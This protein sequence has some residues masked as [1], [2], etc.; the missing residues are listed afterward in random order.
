MVVFD[1]DIE[2]T[3]AD[4]KWNEAIVR[5]R[6]ILNIG[7]GGRDDY[8]SLIQLIRA[9]IRAVA[10]RRTER[11]LGMGFPSSSTLEQLGAHLARES[12]E[13]LLTPALRGERALISILLE[14]LTT[15]RLSFGDFVADH[16]GSSNDVSSMTGHLGWKLYKA[17][18]PADRAFF[19]RT[20][21][22]EIEFA[23]LPPHEQLFQY[24]DFTNRFQ[25]QAIEARQNKERNYTTLLMPGVDKFAETFIRDKALLRC[26]VTA[27]AAERYRLATSEWPKTL[28]DL[29]PV[30]MSAVLLD[31]YDGNPLKYVVR[32]DGFTIYSTGAD[33]QD[34][35]GT[36][37][38][39][40]GREPGA[41]LGFRLWNVESRGLPAVQKP[42]VENQP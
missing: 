3:L 17:R 27:L 12:E 16:G 18:L 25:S 4:Q 30:Y 15:G 41:D 28:D 5:I 1:F 21:N 22:E 9:A 40:S 33:G 8:F 10:V 20:M 34:N 38:T 35:G 42:K 37:L 31:P 39:P 13:D 14:N 6:A 19:L 23:K 7:A 26:A 32:E 29:C 2:R 24:R 11:I 36:N